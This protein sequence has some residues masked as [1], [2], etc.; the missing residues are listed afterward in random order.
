MQFTRP[1]QIAGPQ[2]SRKYLQCAIFYLI[3][4]WI[5]CSLLLSLPL[6]RDINF[7][8]DPGQGHST[9]TLLEMAIF[10]VAS[11]YL[12]AVGF[13]MPSRSTFS[14]VIS[15]RGERDRSFSTWE[16]PRMVLPTVLCLLHFQM[17]LPNVLQLHCY[18]SS[19]V[20][21]L[22]GG[23]CRPSSSGKASGHGCSPSRP[24]SL[25]ALTSWWWYSVIHEENEIS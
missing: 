15:S 3:S 11:R 18:V 8:R 10:T 4:Q 12:P 24:R 22:L 2:F 19:P 14:A 25:Q 20:V 7:H 16:G 13:P 6:S 1:G 23:L 5:A 17:S 9:P 21:A